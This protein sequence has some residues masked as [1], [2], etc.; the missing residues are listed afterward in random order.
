MCQNQTPHE[1][2]TLLIGKSISEEI[3]MHL[4]IQETLA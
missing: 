3:E 1:I 2:Q 4:N